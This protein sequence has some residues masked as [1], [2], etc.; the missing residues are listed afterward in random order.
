MSLPC[1]S[2]LLF[3]FFLGFLTWIIIHKILLQTCIRIPHVSKVQLQARYIKTREGTKHL[4]RIRNIHVHA[5]LG[6]SDSFWPQWLYPAM[7]LCKWNF[8]GNS[9]E[10]SCYF[11]LQLSSY[12]FSIFTAPLLVSFRNRDS[13]SELLFFKKFLSVF[14]QIFKFFQSKLV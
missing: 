3:L 13:H 11:L 8:L 10:V 5:C 9:T 7:L 4:W 2:A 1:S 14:P 12:L 6:V